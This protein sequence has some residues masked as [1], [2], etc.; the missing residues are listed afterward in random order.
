MDYLPFSCFYNNLLCLKVT[1]KIRITWKTKNI[2]FGSIL[3]YLGPIGT[4]LADVDNND[5]DV[6]VKVTTDI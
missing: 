5:Y 2:K 6:L 3:M 1:A 4:T